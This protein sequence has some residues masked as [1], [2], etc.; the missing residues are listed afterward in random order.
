VRRGLTEC[1]NNSDNPSDDSSPVDSVPEPV[2]A[3]SLVEIWDLPLAAADNP[4][5]SVDDCDSGSGKDYRR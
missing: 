5:I 4:V 1:R 2:N 3:V